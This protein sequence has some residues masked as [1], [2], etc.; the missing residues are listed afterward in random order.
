MKKVFTI[1]SLVFAFAGL[2]AQR[3]VDLNVA[4]YSP[5]PDNIIQNGK[6]FDITVSLKNLGTADIKA[7]D[8][9]FIF[10]LL[11]NNFLISGG[12]PLYKGYTGLT[13]AP[14]AS[15]T[16]NAWTGIT[17]TNTT[18]DGKH[19]WCTFAIIQNRSADS[20]RDKNTANNTHC[21]PV[22]LNKFPAGINPDPSNMIVLGGVSAYPNPAT[23]NLT[24][25]YGVTGQSKIS[26]TIRDI[27]GKEVMSVM[28]AESAMGAFETK[29]DVSSLP[30]G[31]YIVEFND[32]N[33]VHST[34]FIKQ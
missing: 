1:L 20:C 11:D 16:I 7:S 21:V 30:A 6:P 18:M 3:N 12:N 24:I 26:I 9:I 14:N 28:N 15:T 23:S 22:W 25:D 17:F 19:D 13:L 32:G 2:Q 4:Q 31:V 33:T 5:G 10:P 27:Q 8:T 34:K 29:V